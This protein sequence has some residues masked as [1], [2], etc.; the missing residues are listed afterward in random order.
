MKCPICKK[1][2]VQAYKP[3]CSATCKDRDLLNWFDESYAVR[4]SDEE[5]GENAFRLRSGDSE[6]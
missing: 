4:G 5:D 3:F 1:L 2:A 6:A